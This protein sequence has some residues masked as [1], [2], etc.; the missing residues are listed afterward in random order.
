MCMKCRALGL[1]S[2]VKLFTLIVE[3][4]S[5]SMK[6]S[7]RLF[8]SRLTDFLPKVRDFQ[9]FSRLLDSLL[10]AQAA[11]LE[12][13]SSAGRRCRLKN[14]LTKRV[15]I[16]YYYGISPPKKKRNG[17]GLLGPNAIKV[18]YMDPLGNECLSG[19]PLLSVF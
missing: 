19:E 15:H 12:W 16:H 4:L 13:D 2:H 8:R 17:D 1:G 10:E 11:T 3:I 7:A 14:L 6:L 5:G 9:N 18:V